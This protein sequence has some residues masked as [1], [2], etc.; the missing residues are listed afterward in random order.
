MT[1]PRSWVDVRAVLNT[2]VE[3][4]IKHILLTVAV[5]FAIFALVFYMVESN[6]NQDLVRAQRA[7]D[8]QTYQSALRIYDTQVTLVNQC[9]TRF[10]S[11][12][13]LRALFVSQ[14]NTLRTMLQIIDLAHPETTSPLL[15]SMFN[16]LDLQDARINDQYPPDEAK[17]CPEMPALPTVPESLIGEVIPTVPATGP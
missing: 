9:N 16:E 11:R 15:L 17:D 2:E 4:K 12:V 8:V 5:A 7:D 13:A 14:N 1:F 6:G 3:T 10:D